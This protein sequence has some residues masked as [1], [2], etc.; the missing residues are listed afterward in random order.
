M[1]ENFDFDEWSSL[2]KIAPDEF[3]T[4][5]HRA[6]EQIISNGSNVR[7]LRG[8]QCRIDLERRRARTPLQACLRLSSM[9]W[10]SFDECRSELNHF[11]RVASGATCGKQTASRPA[12]SA[13]I[14]PFTSARRNIHG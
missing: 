1:A 8:L 7:R 10:D 5:R 4:R 12:K 11:V 13:K 14:I 2:A 6:I 3:E 9:M